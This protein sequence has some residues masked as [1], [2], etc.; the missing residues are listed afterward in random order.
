MKQTRRRFLVQTGAALL[1]SSNL[2]LG[3]NQDHLMTS[4]SIPLF[5]G[6][7]LVGWRAIPR[8]DPSPLLKTERLSAGELTERTTAHYRAQP[9]LAAQLAH[10][11]SWK[12]V[13]GAIVGGQEPAGCGHGAYLITEETF[14]D[15]EL[16]L[17]ARPDWPI[18]SGI[19]VRQHPVGAVGFQVQLDHRPNGGIGGFFTNNTGSFRSSPFYLDGD[20]GADF[21]VSN[22]RPGVYDGKPAVPL[23]SGCNLNDFL[24]VWKPNDWNHFRIRC[25]G[26]LPHLTCWVNGLKT[27]E[28]DFSSVQEPFYDAD[29]IYDRIGPDGHIGFEVHNNDAMARNRWAPGAVSRWRNIRITLL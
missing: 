28:M 25:T 21:T 18:D 1:A 3:S 10:T 13:D 4:N 23:D 14:S 19:M 26:R 15:F 16:E 9:G 17:D 12:V 20:E 7:T 29:G 27:G 6:K 22:L 5:D 24:T 2:S 8:L 11:G